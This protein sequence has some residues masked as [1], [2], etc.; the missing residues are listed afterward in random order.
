[1]SDSIAPPPPPFPPVSPGSRSSALVRKQG[2]WGLW[3]LIGL[4]LGIYYFVWYNRINKELSSVL[5]QPV[6]SD[7]TWWS[8]LIPIYG[9]I[10]LA[11]TAGRLNDAHARLGSPTRVG[12]FMTWFLAPIWF[13]S[14]SR[15]LQR[16]INIL[17]DVLAAKSI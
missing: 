13:G 6:P 8:Q 9:I 16:R 12:V 10:G 3:W 11:R 14:H 17:H 5:A 1:M 2:P 15:Y 7:G 4:T